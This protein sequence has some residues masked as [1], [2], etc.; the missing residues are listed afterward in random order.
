MRS[1]RLLHCT[2]RLNGEI[3]KSCRSQRIGACSCLPS[4][5]FDET[6][7][8]RFYRRR[9]SGDWN[10]VWNYRQLLMCP[11][12][13]ND[14][15]SFDLLDAKLYS[16]TSRQPTTWPIDTWH[17]AIDFSTPLIVRA[18]CRIDLTMI[19]LYVKFPRLRLSYSCYLTKFA[20]DAIPVHMTYIF[21]FGQCMQCC[22]HYY[23]VKRE[24]HC[25]TG[26]TN[27]SNLPSRF[28]R[29]DFSYRFPSPAPILPLPALKI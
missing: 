18:G 29:F 3:E 11:R 10:V 9:H 24:R 12:P 5:N 1:K 4:C 2:V 13:I 25:I 28:T 23:R 16:M 22:R 21:V 27:K 26:H 17:G 19:G 15:A 14:I 20:P 7:L 8:L 6:L